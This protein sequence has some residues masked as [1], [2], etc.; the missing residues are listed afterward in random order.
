[1]AEECVPLT[2]LDLH[3]IEFDQ[4]IY[5]YCGQLV[6]HLVDEQTNEEVSTQTRGTKR[7]LS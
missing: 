1:M 3:R 2:Q 4:E 6:F 7:T 5:H